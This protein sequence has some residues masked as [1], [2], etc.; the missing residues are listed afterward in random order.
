MIAPRLPLVA[1]FL[2]SAV[3]AADNEADPAALRVDLLSAKAT[4]AVALEFRMLG[5]GA[6]QSRHPELAREF[7]EQTVAELRTGKDWVVGY[8]VV[9]GLAQASPTDA[10]AVLPNLAPGYAQIVI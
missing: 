1:A 3:C 7:V 6:L 4:K 9:Q 5:A 8:G 2:A 10:L